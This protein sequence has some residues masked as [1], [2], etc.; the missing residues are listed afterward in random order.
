[1]VERPETFTL[2]PVSATSYRD[3]IEKPLKVLARGEQRLT[4]EPLRVDQ[5]AKDATGADDLPLLAFTLS[6]LYRE[7]GPEGTITLEQYKEK[8]GVSGSIRRAVE[9]ALARPGN[10]PAI[11]AAKAEQDACLRATFIPWLAQIDAESGLA[12]RR[13]ARLDSF[14]SASRAMVRRL[15]EARL[16]VEQ[17][18]TV[19]VAHESLLREWPPLRVWLNADAEDLRLLK[20]VEL[21]A[22]D[23]TRH[24]ADEN[25]LVHQG[26]LLA[27]AE[28]CVARDDFRGR[29]GDEA[30]AYLKACRDRETKTQIAQTMTR[31]RESVHQ[32]KEDRMR[33]TMWLILVLVA[34]AIAWFLLRG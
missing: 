30:V 9:G 29:L 13:V 6:Y 33:T 31:A 18:G 7:F 28:R 24:G 32:L 1:G 14:V 19:E 11:P 17:A 16:L 12:M 21:A 23:W 20:G 8:G 25:W 3:V 27:A 22:R 4:M 34:A 26:T 15:I 2:L 5:L 10:E